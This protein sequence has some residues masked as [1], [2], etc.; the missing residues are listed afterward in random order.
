[1]IYISQ[2]HVNVFLAAGTENFIIQL[3]KNVK[4]AIIIVN[5]VMVQLKMIVQHVQ[6]GIFLKE[7]HVIQH[8]VHINFL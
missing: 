4:V 2:I 8:A 6:L 3:H 5:N 1:M 7:Q